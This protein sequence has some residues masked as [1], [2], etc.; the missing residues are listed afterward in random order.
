M[1]IMGYRL[2]IRCECEGKKTIV[3]FP[4]FFGYISTEDLI[5]TRSWQFLVSKEFVND[6]DAEIFEYDGSPS[7]PPLSAEDFRTFITLYNTDLNTYEHDTGRFIWAKHYGGYYF[8]DEFLLAEEVFDFSSGPDGLIRRKL[9]W[10]DFYW[11]NCPKT[12]SWE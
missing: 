2:T 1:R 4:K 10:H 8:C 3:E 6:E 9:N 12:I 5:K 7:I 11:N